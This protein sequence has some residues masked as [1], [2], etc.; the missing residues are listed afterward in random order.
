MNVLLW[1]VHGSWTTS[2]VHGKHQYLVPV[3]PD[4]GPDGRGRART[5]PWPENA[6]ELTPSQLADADVDIVVLQ[7]PHEAALVERW[8]GRRVGTDLPAVYVE[9]N[10]PSGPAATTRH[11]LADREDLRI[12]HVTHFNSLYWDTGAAR[13]EVVEHGILPPAGTYTAETARLGV[14]TN[15]PI[16]RGRATGTDL[17]AP[18]SAV[19]PL[20]VFGIGVAGL[21]Q[22]L[23]LGPDRIAVHDD[24]DQAELHRRLGSCRVYLHLCRW[25]SLGLS[26]LEAMAIGMPVVAVA[27]TEVVEAVPAGAGVIS[28]R[29]ETLTEA[30]RWLAEDPVAARRMGAQGRHAVRERYGLERF[31]ADW[32]RVLEEEVCGLR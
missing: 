12:V 14:V 15:D 3:T 16:R 31:L 21:P 2:F 32:H 9:H 25:T 5:Y 6:I 10:T 29:I 4:R 28:S 13:T 26:L 24:L 11:H 18:L 20:D 7:R 17:L 19:A 23:G 8:L 27:A 1:H 30:A 22:H